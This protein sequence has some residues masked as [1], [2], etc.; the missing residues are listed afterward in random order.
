[1]GHRC[2]RWLA[3]V[4]LLG[5]AAWVVAI[6]HPSRRGTALRGHE[7]TR[8]FHG[9]SCRYYDA[10]GCTTQF[11]DRREAIAAGFDPCKLCRP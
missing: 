9:P 2:R 5:L 4:G 8:V 6:S 10:E 11:S 1:M 3:W 7:G